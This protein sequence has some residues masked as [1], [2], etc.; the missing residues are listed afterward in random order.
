MFKILW[1]LFQRNPVA[2]LLTVSVFLFQL[3]TNLTSSWLETVFGQTPA[4]LIRITVFIAALAA[5]LY[6]LAGA[7]RLAPQSWSSV[8]RDLLPSPRQGLILTVGPG[9]KDGGAD[10]KQN[11]A[12]L[13]AHYHRKGGKLKTVWAVT[14]REGLPTKNQLEAELGG[15]PVFEVIVNNQHSVAETYQAV[16]KIY[17]ELIPASGIPPEEVIADFTGGTKEMSVGLA[18]ACANLL[19]MQFVSG[20]HG[21]EASEPMQTDFK[22][23]W[24]EQAKKEA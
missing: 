15:I 2:V 5:A 7:L 19:P 13:A 17:Q 8:P 11:T 12:Y 23:G 3:V 24:P 20:P 1:R 16:E 6:I 18:L 9:R 22:P 14:T 10:F 21:S 4:M